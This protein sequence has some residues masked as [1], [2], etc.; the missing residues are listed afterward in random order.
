KLKV[1]KKYFN[2]YFTKEFIRVSMF[3]I[4]V[5]VIFIKKLNKALRFYVDYYK[6]NT[7]IKKN[8]YLILLI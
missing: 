1:L 8:A 2:N 4:T 5:L 3:F 6:L 7:I